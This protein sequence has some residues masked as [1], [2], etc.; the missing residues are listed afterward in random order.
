MDP[1]QLPGT[2]GLLTACALALLAAL[3]TS[4][5]A[6][7]LPWT[8]PGVEKTSFV[9]V[10]EIIL[11]P[12]EG[13][14]Y[15]LMGVWLLLDEKDEIKYMLAPDVRYNETKGVFPTLRLFG[16]PS[17]TRRYSLA[18]GKSTTIDENY[19]FEYADRGLWEK[20]AFFLAKAGY[21]RDSTERF[22]GF[23]NTSREDDESN[24]TGEEFLADATP[25]FWIV[26]TVNVSYR[27]RIRRYAVAHGQVDG[28]PFIDAPRFRRNPRTDVRARGLDAGVYWA[29]KL[30]VAYDT[31]DSIDLPTQ[32]ALSQ[33]YVDAADRTLG[34]KTSYMK[35]GFET[36]GFIPLR[37][38]KRNP[39]IALRALADYVS[40]PKDTP[41][42]ERSSLGGRRTLRGY[43][44][45]RFIGFNR[46]LGTAE[47]RTRVYQ[48]R[49]FGVKAEL[50]LAPF[51]E[52]G[53][54]WKGVTNSPVDDL[55]W[56]YGLGFR[57]IVA[58]QIVAFVD[59]GQGTEG[60]SIFTGIDYPF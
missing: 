56:V 60:M 17:D 51:V 28:V 54:V 30:A 16:Y 39:I 49:L 11:D 59:V 33:I 22:Y 5:T 38:E 35:F 13:N 48:R 23:G 53:Q 46:S 27:M 10:P 44:G 50:E 21:E 36:R 12:N 15:G 6:F 24:Y 55:H 37:G 25:G 9:P 43:G 20:R 2:R 29:H 32:G 1:R 52:A 18:V 4:A 19:E 41:F 58:P 26:P 42:W 14:T 45:D 40:G 8:P 3:A 47:L 57:G 31:R 7:E 34:S